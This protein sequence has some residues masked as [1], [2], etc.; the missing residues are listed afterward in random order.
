[1]SRDA[2][3]GRG[4][5]SLDSIE[6]D[7]ARVLRRVTTFPAAT[8]RGRW[9]LADGLSADPV[10]V[11]ALCSSAQET[12]DL[13][14][15]RVTVGEALFLDTETTGLSGGAG[16]HVFLLGCARFVGDAFEVRQWVLPDPA[17]ELALLG[18][19][20]DEVATAAGLVTFNGRNFD[21]PL[22]EERCV[23]AGVRSPFGPAPHAD[24]LAGA[25]RI[26][27]LRA[28]RVSLRNLEETVLGIRRVDDLPGSE[29]PAA[30]YAFL[31]GDSAPLLR[32]L[33]HNLDDLLSL[34]PLVAALA[35]AARGDAPAPDLHSA[36]RALVRALPGGATETRALTLQRAAS[37]TA[38]DGVLAAKA[39]EEASRLLRR[40][41]ESA[42]AALEAHAATLADPALPGPWI[43]LAKDAEHRTGDLELALACARKA[44][45]SLFLRGRGA[46]QRRDLAVRITRLEAKLR[47]RRAGEASGPPDA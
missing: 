35:A 9:S 13:P 20:R 44:E 19:L 39:H 16:T 12:R 32:V 26:L 37:R 6:R 18:A 36:G 2:G 15:P 22:L 24:L 47:A 43:A 28:R 21:V 10:D 34:P 4:A 17:D 46:A 33:D 31:R 45:R 42:E 41:G 5:A 30:W 25:R 3:P 38:D 11:G 8:R 27:R 1:M 23:L 14:P 7:G 40:R 29:C